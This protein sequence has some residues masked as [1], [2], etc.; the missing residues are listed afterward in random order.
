MVN[1]VPASEKRSK[2][3]S[4]G[5]ISP[6]PKKARPNTNGPSAKATLENVSDD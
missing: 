1:K 4:A 2:S 3:S 6:H 5:G